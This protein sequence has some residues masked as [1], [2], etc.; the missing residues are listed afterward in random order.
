MNKDPDYELFINWL[1]ENGH[2]ERFKTTHMKIR[3]EILYQQCSPE[4]YIVMC[5]MVSGYDG[6]WDLL[7]YEWKEFYKQVSVL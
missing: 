1:K 3:P 2:Y 6:Y 7:N 5:V 4:G